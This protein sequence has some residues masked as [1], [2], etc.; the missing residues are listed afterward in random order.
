MTMTVFDIP[1][2]RLS[3]L[4]DTALRELVARLCEAERERNGGHRTEVRWGGAQTAADGGLDVMVHVASDCEPTPVLLRK[5][6]GIQV[7]KSDLRRSGIVAEMRPAG[8]LRESI[9][10]IAQQGGAYLIVSVGVDCSKKMLDDRRRAMR[11][12]L[13]PDPHAAE[14]YTDFIDR[15]A[16]A[17]WVSVHPSV[18]LWLRERLGLPTLRGWV[19]YSRWSSTPR[20]VDDTLICEQGL[21]FRLPGHELF[22]TV[23]E[24]LE[25]IRTL[26]REGRK[27]IR[28]AGLSGIG[29]TRLVQALF[30]EMDIGEPLP[31]SSAVYADTGQDPEPLPLSMLEM[32]FFTQN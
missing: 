20:G 21:K 18:S 10:D 13:G 9:Q 3:E 27:A 14:L 32:L 30:E 23:P 7:K 2:E 11:Q 25:A 6:V 28:I 16:V 26:V 19:G 17:R 5:L 24:A 15:H 4:D 31:R 12:A 22:E 8:A 1:A 29:K